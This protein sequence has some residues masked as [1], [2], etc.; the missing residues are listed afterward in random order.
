M[1]ITLY[2]NAE[3]VIH[4]EVWQ[5]LVYRI[6]AFGATRLR[7][8]G[9]DIRPSYK[10]YEKLRNWQ[11]Y[12]D[13]DIARELHIRSGCLSEWKTGRSCP[14]VDKLYRIAQFF[15]VKIED[16]LEDTD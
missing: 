13:A 5:F 7:K 10:I 2:V 12:R 1:F 11:Q 3:S 14:N 6:S 8:G 9:I 15:G 16:L 4:F